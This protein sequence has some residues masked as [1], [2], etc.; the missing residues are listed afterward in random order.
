MKELKAPD[1]VT[2][3]MTHDGAVAENLSTGE[4]TNISS[5]EAETDF[6][7]DREPLQ[8]AEAAAERA[9]HAH[10]RHKAKQAARADAETVRAGS[11]ARG[12]PS[13]RLQFTD[14]ELAAPDLRKAIRRSDRAADKLD[15]AKEAIPTRRV[16]KTERVFDEAAGKGKTRLRFEEVEKKPNGHLRH[17]PL[18]RPVQELK[19]TAHGRSARW[20]TKM[21]AWRPGTRARNWRSAVW[22][23]RRAV[24][25]PL[26]GS[27][28]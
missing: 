20:S 11:E 4:V 21:W 13:S 8:T 1:K 3:K 10:D 27:A 2:Q 22:L 24:F 5:R 25:V 15:A 23:V 9:A 28:A 19:A 26:S 12:R 14:E 6:S 17:N 18:A 7:A 16:L